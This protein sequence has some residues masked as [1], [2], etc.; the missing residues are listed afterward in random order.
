MAQHALILIDLQQ[1]YFPGGRFPL[2]DVEAAAGQ[3]ASLLDAAR[4]SGTPVIHVRHEFPGEDAPF[5]VRGTPGVAIHP[6]VAPQG[7]E[8]VITKAFPNAF[9]DTDLQTLIDDLGVEAVVLA[10]AMAHICVDSTA[11]AA[12]DLGLSVTVIHDAVATRDLSFGD[13]EVPARQ[14]HAA[15][16]AALGFGI[17]AVQSAQ[18][19]RESLSVAASEG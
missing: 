9:R 11:R 3:A 18:E 8:P 7:V 2:V 1:D 13:V 14:V 12:A 19:Y 6:L 5:F 17:A 4:R 15:F 16:L 10:G